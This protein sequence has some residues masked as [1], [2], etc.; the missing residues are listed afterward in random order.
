[1]RH[2]PH[3]DLPFSDWRCLS[4]QPGSGNARICYRGF[5]KE[6]A[7]AALLMQGRTRP[8]PE[9]NLLRDELSD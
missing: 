9:R 7:A 4:K 5:S 8:E 2:F 1:M 3:G 6:K